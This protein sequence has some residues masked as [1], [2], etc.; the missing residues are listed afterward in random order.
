MNEKEFKELI[1]QLEKAGRK[2]EVCDVRIP[3]FENRVHCGDPT[4]IGDVVEK[5]ADWYPSS[6]FEEGKVYRAQAIGDSMEN[7]EIE[8]GDTLTLVAGGRISDGDIVLVALDDDFTVKAYFED[9]DGEK[10]LVPYNEKYP[11]IHLHEGMNIQVKGRVIDVSKGAPRASSRESRRL[12]RLHKERSTTKKE[13]GPQQVSQALRKIAPMVMLARQ[14]YAV[15]RAM[16]DLSLISEN[17][18]DHFVDM[19]TVELPQ[20]PC[21]PTRLELHRMAT[22]S[23][24]KPVALWRA[25]NAPVQG[26]RF[27]AYMN[28]ARMMKD[29]LEAA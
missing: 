19:V 18:F 5:G 12:V 25:D 27:V 11:S 9:D 20:H 10:W 16:V 13:I 22:L 15:Y 6:K 8:D 1:A 17:D 28:I 14:W 7:L 24:T 4:G 26:K 21:L 29:L 3:V 2:P 23:F